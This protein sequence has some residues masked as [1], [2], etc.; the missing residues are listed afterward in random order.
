MTPHYIAISYE[1]TIARL[2]H[3]IS[4]LKITCPK[5]DIT[6]I[7]IVKK[8]YSA[9]TIFLNLDCCSPNYAILFANQFYERQILSILEPIYN[10]SNL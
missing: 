8:D 6:H 1:Y 9:C 4:S 7:I 3:A 5:I 2:N 10:S